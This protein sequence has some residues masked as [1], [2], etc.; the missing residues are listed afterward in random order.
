MFLRWTRAPRKLDWV[1]QTVQ[2]GYTD[3][4]QIVDGLQKKEKEGYRAGGVAVITAAKSLL[5]IP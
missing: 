5:L 2:L 3:A 1:L 4:S